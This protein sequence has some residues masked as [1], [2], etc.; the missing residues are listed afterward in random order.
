MKALKAKLLMNP[1]KVLKE[2]I[3]SLDK[4]LKQKL[5]STSHTKRLLRRHLRWLK[6]SQ[7][8]NLTETKTGDQ[9]KQSSSKGVV[10]QGNSTFDSSA[11]RMENEQY[12]NTLRQKVDNLQSVM[13]SGSATP[14]Q[15]NAAVTEVN[16]A[17]NDVNSNIEYKKQQDAQA[18]AQAATAA[19]AAAQAQQQQQQQAA[20]TYYPN[21][22]AVQAAG[23]A[24]LY[25]GQPGY[26]SKLDRDKDGVACE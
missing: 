12:R 11:G 8:L 26:S 4:I 5:T 16:Q 14:E 25:Q 15:I 7:K 3:D 6:Q 20:N 18:A 10:E 1:R 13:N 22:A 9:A 23:A 21:C 24:P 17:V 19:Q 2:K